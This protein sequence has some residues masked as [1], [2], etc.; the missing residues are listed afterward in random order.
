MVSSS[1]IQLIEDIKL[2]MKTFRCE[3][4]DVK[5]EIYK[6]NVLEQ[7]QYFLNHYSNLLERVPLL[8]RLF[9]LCFDNLE[10]KFVCYA[11][12]LK[13]AI[14]MIKAQMLNL[15]GENTVHIS[16]I[17]NAVNRIIECANVYIDE[18]QKYHNLSVEFNEK[19]IQLMAHPKHFWELFNNNF[20]NDNVSENSNVDLTKYKLT[21][22]NTRG[23]E[24]ST[25]CSDYIASWIMENSSGHTIVVHVFLNSFKYNYNNYITYEEI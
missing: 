5:Y 8:E 4:M 21:T 23:T 24:I 25:E 6:N 14:S 17:S 13:N 1:R 18:A 7:K 16:N 11:E 20:A 10:S 2:I 15:V 12:Y 9:N 3:N 19:M 22:R